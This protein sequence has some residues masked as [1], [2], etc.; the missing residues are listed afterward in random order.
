MK[1]RPS[2]PITS[3]SGRCMLG[4]QPGYYESSRVMRAVMQSQGVEIDQLRTA[5]DETMPQFFVRTATWGITFWERLLGIPVDSRI[6]L[7]RRRAKVLARMQVSGP[8]TRRRMVGIVSQ[9]LSSGDARIA[10]RFADYAFDVILPWVNF[11]FTGIVGRVEEIKPAHLA[12]LY[13]ARAIDDVFWLATGYRETC[14]PYPFCNIERTAPTPGVPLGLVLHFGTAL[15]PVNWDYQ[16]SGILT[17]AGRPGKGYPSVLDINTD[18]S[19]GRLFPF[20]ICNIEHTYTRPGIPIR[21]LLPVETDSRWAAW[22]FEMC[23]AVKYQD[24]IGKKLLVFESVRAGLFGYRLCD[25]QHVITTG[26][27]P[28]LM[29]LGMWTAVKHLDSR[30]ALCGSLHALERPGKGYCARLGV[31]AEGVYNQLFSYPLCNIEHTGPL[32]GIITQL[33]LPI[34][35]VAQLGKWVYDRCGVVHMPGWSGAVAH[36]DVRITDKVMVNNHNYQ[37]CDQVDPAGDKGHLQIDTM[38]VKPKRMHI[39][40][41]YDMCGQKLARS[42]AA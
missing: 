38:C 42:D 22:G 18:G 5:L 36:G 24:R 25:R 14:I 11:D 39:D 9:F 23:G 27:V 28:V 8:M 26:G 7:E 33:Q 12:A 3:T 37:F 32:P 6:P 31:S 34:G 21:L 17:T 19:Y 30:Y 20:S 15:K 10:E 40:W 1:N 29:P 16:L 4:Y 2:L 13:E 35:F 41:Q